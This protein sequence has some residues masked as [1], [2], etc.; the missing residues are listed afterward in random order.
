MISGQESVKMNEERSWKYMLK[1]LGAQIKEFKTPSIITPLCM[2]LEVVMEM[3]IP[4]MMASIV[5]GGVGK[6]DMSHIYLMGGCM[7]LAALVS[8]SAGFAGGY[9]GAKAST[10]FARN[11]RDAM[12]ANIQSFS[13]AN[14]DKYRCD[15]YSECL[16]DDSADVYPGTFFANL[17]N[18]YVILHKPQGGDGLFGGGVYS[19]GLP[20][21]DCHTDNEDIPQHFRK[22]R[23]IEC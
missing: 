19:G 17:C 2:M 10:G 12:F 18:G 21:A 23:C 14:I 6:G 22:I 13:F 16:S 8:L 9:F 11:L 15:Q 5:D 4:L 3:I 20:D 7:V 1:T